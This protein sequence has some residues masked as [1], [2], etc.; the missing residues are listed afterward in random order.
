MSE[1]TD[2]NFQKE[3]IDASKK[4]PVVVDFWAPWCGPCLMLGPIMEKLEKEY[5][6]KVKIVKLN[7]DDSQE[8]AQE[9]N[10]MS[11]PAV[12]MFKD[13]KVADEFIGAQPESAVKK[14]IDSNI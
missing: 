10:I 8:R 7:V 2:S 1:V 13:G 14:W 6:G 5:K 9:Y 4:M 12:K 11:I 3:V